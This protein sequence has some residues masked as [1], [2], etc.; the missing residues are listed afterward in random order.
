MTNKD[1]LEYAGGR[2]FGTTGRVMFLNF[3]NLLYYIDKNH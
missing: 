2:C 1:T 3:Y